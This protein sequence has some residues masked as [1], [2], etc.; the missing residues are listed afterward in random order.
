MA[1]EYHYK[2]TDEVNDYHIRG[3]LKSDWVLSEFKSYIIVTD[4]INKWTSNLEDLIKS[5]IRDKKIDNLFGNE[6]I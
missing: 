2:S 1:K 4:N 3:E 5:Y 6:D